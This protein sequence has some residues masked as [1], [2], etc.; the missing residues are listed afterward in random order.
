MSDE[1]ERE[2]GPVPGGGPREGEEVTSPPNPNPAAVH[3]DHQQTVP[4]GG[5][6]PEAAE[7]ADAQA[8]EVDTDN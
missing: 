4:G 7:S 1:K 8:E 2:S 5:P 6:A 3:P